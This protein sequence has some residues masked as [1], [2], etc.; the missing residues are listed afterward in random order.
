MKFENGVK[1]FEDIFNRKR[2]KNYRDFST[3]L[4][5]LHLTA[6]DNKFIKNANY[7]SS[8]S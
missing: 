3:T 5:G 2:D 6:L 7:T 1:E 8:Y 4:T